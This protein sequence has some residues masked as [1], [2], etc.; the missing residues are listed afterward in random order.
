[1]RVQL[2]LYI[3]HY[4]Y[5]ARTSQRSACCSNSEHFVVGRITYHTHAADDREKMSV[6]KCFELLNVT[7]GRAHVLTHHPHGFDWSY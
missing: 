1:M 2:Q 5:I 3:G 7:K 6:F 4:F